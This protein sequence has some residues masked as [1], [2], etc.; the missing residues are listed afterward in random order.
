MF[1]RIFCFLFLLMPV[2]VWG[3]HNRGGEITYIHL[4]GLTYE[5]TITTCTDLGSVTGTDRP[6]L[7]LDFDLGTSFAQRDTLLRDS[8]LP[9]SLN[10]KKNIYIGIHTFTSTGSHRITM[11]DP[12]RNA[13]I[14]NIWPGG[15]SDD[16]VF[17]LETFLIISPVL[18]A[19]G[20]NNS[21][22]FT[23]CPCPAVGCLN[24][25]YCYNPM[26]YDPDGDSLSYELVVPLGQDA[27]P[28]LLGSYYVFP[29]AIG[30]GNFTI[31]PVFGTVCWNNPLMVGEF[32]FTILISEW[33]NGYKIGS[34]IRDIQLTIS[35]N[36][37]N[38]PPDI[39][40]IDDTCVR[41][42]S[43]LNI[44]IQGTDQDLDFITLITA[45]LSFNLNNSP[46]VFSS[47]ATNGV[48]NG[49]FQWNTNC[50]QIQQSSYQVLIE[51]E[52]NG[53]PVLS[54]YEAF[55]IEVRPPAITGLIASPLGN[56]IR[57]IWDKAICSNALGYNI[58]KKLGTI[59][60]YEE[61]CQSSNL[62]NYG[63]SLVHQSVS[64]SDTTFIDFD[65]LEIGNSYC[66]FVT[67]IYDF[68]QVESCPSDT[69]CS[70]VQNEVAI[71]T[72]VSVVRTDSLIGIDS[73]NWINP[74]ELDTNQYQGPYHYEIASSN[75]NIIQQFLPKNF[76]YQ[77]E[78]SFS[79]LNTNTLDTNR[80]YKV[81]LYYTFLNSDSLVGYSNPATS[82]HLRTIPN[83]NQ[84]EL[85]WNENV[86]WNNNMYFI[87]RSDSIDGNYSLI[88]S[89]IGNYFLDSGLTN[90]IQYCYHIK[91]IGEYSDSSIIRPLINF[92]QKACDV[93]FD[94]TPPC[95]PTITL[96]GDCD[97][98]INTL[99]WTNPNN[100]CSDDAV[101]YSLYFTQ[102]LDSAYSLINFFDNI[103]DT[104]F[105]H[106]NQYNGENS[107]AGCYY[108]TA[109]DS[110][111]YNN[112]S[113][114]SD[115][116]CFD[117]CPNYIFPNIFTPNGD[118]VNDY[119]QAIMPIKYIDNIELYILNRW[120]EVVFKTIDPE[121]L[122]DGTAEETQ[123]NC[124]SGT[125]YFQ[126]LV[127]SIRLFGIE[128][129]ELNGHVQLT[130][131]NISNNQ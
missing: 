99:N 30:G 91:S 123:Q 116:V 5:F 65:S 121:F 127:N 7:F 6:E 41:A 36:C 24:R 94:Y 60:T 98:E 61:C 107:I 124:P 46:S 114:P 43:T 48:A 84:I 77:L 32:N 126:C 67:A 103:K 38:N 16:A 8:Q 49:I 1:L 75:G 129:I 109:T 17:A 79:T 52:D 19:S 71:L 53:I 66:Y 69:A 2:F 130:R 108:L 110:M 125:Y 50:S 34:V 45:G 23:E 128:T 106:Q 72:N 29:D 4:G 104:T 87:F 13:G 20:G 26:S 78:N 21:V 33:R 93:P 113:L 42:G 82:V 68:G 9:L 112:E 88:D 90:R 37:S 25:P 28:L 57:L 131:K 3:S 92:S 83:D 100:S 119:F 86:P 27:L 118:G 44:N 56:S 105:Q 39:V 80:N 31:D 22:Q 81:G 89:A 74:N 122:W 102:F 73:I 12:N 59:N 47:V 55:N 111:I 35:N 64:N 117:N 18:G 76:L 11:E 95:P 58:Y 70:I 97:L 85:F 101:S 62:S 14:L 15:N 10:H 120:G 54:D 63:V 115:T 51:L 40:P 96:Q